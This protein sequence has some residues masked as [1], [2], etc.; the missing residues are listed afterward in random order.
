MTVLRTL[1][2]APILRAVLISLFAGWI[3]AAAFGLLIARLQYDEVTRY[4]PPEK[5]TSEYESRLDREL[6]TGP[7]LLMAQVG[8]VAGVLAWQVGKT[9]RQAPAPIVYGAAAALV[10]AAIESLVALAMQV[11]WLFILALI[12]ILI[13]VGVFAGWSIKGDTAVAST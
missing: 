1:Q 10:L 6:R 7:L 12:G 2:P 8:V 4:F 5:V 3:V 11:P 9:A 13:G